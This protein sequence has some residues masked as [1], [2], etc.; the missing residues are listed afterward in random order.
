MLFIR[1]ISG[2]IILDG[3]VEEGNE[4]IIDITAKATDV[5]KIVGFVETYPQSSQNPII[6]ITGVS[7]CIVHTYTNGFSRVI[8]KFKATSRGQLRLTNQWSLGEVLIERIDLYC[9]VNKSY[10]ILPKLTAMPSVGTHSKG[11]IVY[12]SKPTAGGNLGWVCIT[13]GSP[14]TW[15]PFGSIQN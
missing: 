4:Y 6:S 14:G 2:Y 13:A 3:N 1:Y 10:S 5:N 8:H 12:N 9:S 7:N 15:K 11:D